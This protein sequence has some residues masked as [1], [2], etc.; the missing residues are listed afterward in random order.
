MQQLYSKHRKN[1][2]EYNGYSIIYPLEKMDIKHLE[3]LI[4]TIELA[5]KNKRW[6][7][8]RVD[9]HLPIES[10]CSE[11][12]L[13][14]KFISSLKS[15]VSYSRSKALLHNPKAHS[16]KIRYAWAKEYTSKHN[17]H[18]H[19]IFIVNWD[20]YN[21]IGSYKAGHD[22]LYNRL[23]NAWA[24]ALGIDFARARQLIH[25]PAN[26]RY[27]VNTDDQNSVDDFFYRASYLCK[28]DTKAY[29]TRHCFGA[30]RK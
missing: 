20:A 26:H 27:R 6:F 29:G 17:S 1:A 18:Y 3:K 13:I 7:A 10:Y 2:K 8:F 23:V 30:S 5:R 19:F 4:K 28:K 22:N 12:R 11:H 14:D 25:I 21:T 15:Q 24:R 9:L 16:T